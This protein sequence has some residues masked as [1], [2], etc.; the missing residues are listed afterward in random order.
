MS[1]RG[2]T[3][4]IKVLGGTSGKGTEDMSL[5]VALHS[6]LEVLKEQLSQ[7]TGEYESNPNQV[8]IES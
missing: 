6:P 7:F 1:G 8:K 3:I 4:T 2:V 5:P